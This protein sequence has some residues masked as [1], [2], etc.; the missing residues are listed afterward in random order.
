[1]LKQINIQKGKNFAASSQSAILQH[2]RLEH[3]ERSI[4]NLYKNSK[5]GS[6]KTKQWNTITAVECLIIN[7]VFS[8]INLN[9][10]KLDLKF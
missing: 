2:I 4:V 6:K 10:K 9:H 3:K 5:P 1:M 7:E 8:E